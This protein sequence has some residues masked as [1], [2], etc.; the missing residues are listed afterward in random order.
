MDWA[1]AAMSSVGL[2]STLEFRPGAIV[3]APGHEEFCAGRTAPSPGRIGTA[4]NRLSS[5]LFSLSLRSLSEFVTTA[6]RKLRGVSDCGKMSC[7][8]SLRRGRFVTFR[9]VGGCAAQ[10]MVSRTPAR[11]RRL[12]SCRC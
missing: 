2:L 1:L 3:L 9:G 4:Q 10:R 7:D 12:G 5:N 8:D 6:R 11:H